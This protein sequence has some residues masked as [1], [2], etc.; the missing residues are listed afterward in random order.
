V[1]H[2]NT[3]DSLY[4]QGQ[5][6]FIHYYSPRRGRYVA[7]RLNLSGRG[8]EKIA[9]NLS[10]FFWN[11]QAANT[12]QSM[13]EW[14]RSNGSNCYANIC[15]IIYNDIKENPQYNYLPEWVINDVETAIR[16]LKTLV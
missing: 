14:K 8:S 11:L 16:Y 3:L 4:I 5:I 13:N 1:A 9:D 15:L 7:N 6:R 2:S 10:G 12:V